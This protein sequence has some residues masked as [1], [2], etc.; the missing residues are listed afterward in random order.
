[1]PAVYEKL[2]IRFQYPENW[3]LDEVEAL[4][5]NNSVAVY[6]PGGGFWSIMIHPPEA[7]P[8]DL[9]EAALN[10]MRQQYDELDA[11]SVAETLAGRRLVGY[12]MNFFYLDLTSTAL[13][14]S[15]ATERAAYVVFCQ[16][17]DR[18]FADIELVFRAITASLLK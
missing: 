11:E 6:S 17:D 12:D 2:G 3:T 16:A 1:M 15:F 9:V 4:E 14:R 8:E 13:V 5:G 7:S 10:V 18:E